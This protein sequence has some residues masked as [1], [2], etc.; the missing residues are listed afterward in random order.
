MLVQSTKASSCMSSISLFDM[1]KFCKLPSP[2]KTLSSTLDKLLWLSRRSC[3][4]PRS[5]NG[6]GLLPNE[7]IL[8]QERSITLKLLQPFKFGTTRISLLFSSLQK[9]WYGIRL[10]VIKVQSVGKKRTLSTVAL[11]VHN[12]A[13]FWTKSVG[14]RLV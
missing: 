9:L 11:I 10:K 14:S 1:S 4:I 13:G 6:V 8:F 3:S 12:F 7:V 5:I 2:L